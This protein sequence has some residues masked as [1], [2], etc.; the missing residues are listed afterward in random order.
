M[1]VYVRYVNLD[2]G[3]GTGIFIEVYDNSSG[4]AV[5]T[6][7]A[8]IDLGS[9]QGK[10][11]AGR[12]SVKYIV[13]KLKTMT[14]PTIGALVLS[15][16]D[17]DH[18]NL[19]KDLLT[20]FKPYGGVASKETLKIN[21]ALYGSDYGNFK[22]GRGKQTNAL[23]DVK[24]YMAMSANREPDPAAES[25][26]SFLATPPE[27]VATAGA[28]KLYL[29]AGNYPDAGPSGEGGSKKRQRQDAFA[30]NTHSLVV[31]VAFG[32]RTIVATG[33]ATGATL[34]F[35]V[36]TLA[37]PDCK[38]I[39]DKVLSVGLPH[40]GSEVTTFDTGFVDAGGKTPQQILTEFATGLKARTV[41]GSAGFKTNF[42]HPSARVIEYFWKQLP[43][44][45]TAPMFSNPG[46]GNR[47]FYTAYFEKDQYKYSA[48]LTATLTGWPP[49]NLKEAW[50]TV[51]TAYDIY[52][53]IYYSA[54]HAQRLANSRTKLVPPLPVT[55]VSLPNT[56]ADNSAGVAPPLGVSWVYTIQEDGSATL[57]QETNRLRMPRAV[58]APA[59]AGRPQP[60]PYLRPAPAAA[61]DPGRRGAPLRGLEVIL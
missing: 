46:L 37:I 51:Q 42:L 11:K 2:V 4:T 48:G 13:D 52:T 57:T 30:I 32:G 36:T 31:I 61:H 10:T 14:Q 41:T 27:P 1:A 25:S 43:T 7:T 29:L 8:L 49:S 47:H 17:S 35:C 53:N 15:H 55:T 39:L 54:S 38:R 56:V 45:D 60:L 20:K 59:V 21:F 26:S 22:K 5:L 24:K 12:P 34:R 16:S 33:D 58:A 44:T 40:H 3:Q 23:G 28:V 19:L 18:I 9:E 6:D 50:Y